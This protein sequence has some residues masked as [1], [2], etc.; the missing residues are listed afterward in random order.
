MSETTEPTKVEIAF[1][2][3]KGLDGSFSTIPELDTKLEVSREATRGDVKA[4]SFELLDA[5]QRGD[6]ANSVVIGLLSQ[7]QQQ[8][9]QE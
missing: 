7:Q 1:L 6:I 9:P 3:V 5:I 4:A 2:V 8:Q